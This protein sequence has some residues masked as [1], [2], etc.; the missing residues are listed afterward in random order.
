LKHF[1][2]FFRLLPDRTDCKRNWS[3]MRPQIRT[4]KYEV[5]AVN[6][7]GKSTEGQQ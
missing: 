4:K 2:D 6:P 3:V 5:K 7:N 1:E